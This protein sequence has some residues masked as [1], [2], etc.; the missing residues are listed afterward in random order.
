MF[1]GVQGCSLDPAM[2][3][4]W[5]AGRGVDTGRDMSLGYE[6]G[7]CWIAAAEQSR[8]TT[9]MKLCA[10]LGVAGSGWEWMDVT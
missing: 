9:E 8:T 3:V 10:W 2:T 7:H 5:S 1:P 4:P 6:S